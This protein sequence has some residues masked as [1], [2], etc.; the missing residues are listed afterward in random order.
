M[1]CDERRLLDQWIS[2]WQDLVEFEIIPV[3]TSAEAA[4]ALSP[5]L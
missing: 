1:E 4:A 2:N 3:M 5:K